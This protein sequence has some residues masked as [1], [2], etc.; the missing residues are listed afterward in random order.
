MTHDAQ[1]TAQRSTWPHHP[2]TTTSLTSHHTRAPVGV[3]MH[4]HC[5]ALWLHLQQ[6]RGQALT[7]WQLRQAEQEAYLWESSSSRH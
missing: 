6:L 5:C 1:C 3:M 7:G 2:S 4:V